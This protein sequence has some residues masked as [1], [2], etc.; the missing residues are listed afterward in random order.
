VKSVFL[1]AVLIFAVVP[2]ATA[3]T[4]TGACRVIDSVAVEG[5]VRLDEA[6]VLS[7]AGIATGA[8]TCRTEIQLAI[9]R[10]YGTGQVADVR[11]F[12]TRVD[13]RQ[14]LIF[15]VQE[16]PMLARWEVRGPDELSERSVR[17]R[18]RL[19][20]GR[21]F[22]P[23]SAARSRA[24]IDSLYKERGHYFSEVSLRV[25][26]RDDGSVVAI[27]DI[28]EGRKIA[29]SQVVVEGNEEFDDEAI[30][31]AMNTG[32]EGF[33]WW[34]NGAYS[35]DTVDRDIRERLPD[36]FGSRGFIDF[37]VV[38]D[39]LVVHEETGKG[40]L[41]LDVDEGDEYT[42]GNFDIV[43]N[44]HFSIE[45]LQ[46]LFP[47]GRAE[48][49][50][51]GLG[52]ARSGPE[53]F[54]QGAWQDA[55]DQLNQLYANNGYIYARVT[56]QAVRRVNADSTRSVDLQWEIAEGAPAIVNRV[57]VRG[58][59]VTHEN[60]IRRVI[61]VVPG[62]VFRQDALIQS[63]QRISNLGFFEEPLAVPT[64]NQANNQGDIDIIFQV[65]ERHT[66]SVQ[67][68]ASVGQGV[69]VGGFVGFEDPNLFGRGKQVNLNWQFGRQINDLRLSYTDPSLRGSLVS[70]TVSLHR[71]RLRYTVADL[72]RINTRGGSLQFGFPLFGSRFTRIMTTYSLEQSEYDSPRL[73]SR[74]MCR[75]CLLS[76]VGLS[77]VRD[78]RIGLPFATAGTM[79]QIAV[80]QNGGP[81][82]G[83]GSFQRATFEGRWYA[84]LG[85]LGGGADL[86]SQGVQF[87]LGLTA[88]SGFVWGDIGP[89]FRQLFSMGGTQFG[90][91]LRGYDEF[92]VTPAGFDA[93][94][95][96][97]YANT[98][99]A[100]GGAYQAFTAE[101][102]ARLSQALY[103]STF[104]DAGNVWTEPAEFNPT[105]LFRGMGVGVSLLSPLG[106]IGID[107]AYGFDRRDLLGNRD[108]GWKFHFKLGMMQ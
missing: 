36:Y 44:R 30:V 29:L 19:L 4:G 103:L 64:T 59:T 15:T 65:Q 33:W 73:S 43:G 48:T 42:V 39:T 41:L 72:G 101:I 100:F 61:S 49:G 18:V 25:E 14:I 23:A 40:T 53:Q 57:I 90:I 7:R 70:S 38:R 56:P 21:P 92:S 52:S 6:T 77:L 98:V 104:V 28:E 32:P 105:R 85:Q 10:I 80:T 5:A 55:T 9:E 16:R 95:S 89:H 74:F 47:F 12:Q 102:G 78:T 106:P 34:K 46:T 1:A 13:A 31:S 50:F 94:A 35:D 97:Y 27:F 67:F 69:G 107:Y 26:P 71:S 88:K 22:D 62:D 17:G 3:Q 79:H 24:G 84:P 86:G 93:R 99:A 51:L 66:G 68:G 82:G 96:G 63:Y 75:N 20:E 83:A 60:V 76:S 2:L 91:P 8:Q 87:V 81:L 58:N 45:Q 108:P 11:V 37:R 54:D